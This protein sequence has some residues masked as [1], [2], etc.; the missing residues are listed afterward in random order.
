MTLWGGG[1]ADGPSELLWQFTVD[2]ADRRLLVD[3]VRGSL[4]HVAMLGA[5]GVLDDDETTGITTG[6]QTVLAEAE[7]GEFAWSD[8]DEDVHTAVERRLTELIGDDVDRQGRGRRTLERDV[9]GRA[10]RWKSLIFKGLRARC[11]GGWRG[12]T[13][14]SYGRRVKIR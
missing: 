2:Q 12:R 4:A 3:D 9:A 11:D 6:L 5:V 1:F 8:T 10:A 7:A 13:A 14:S